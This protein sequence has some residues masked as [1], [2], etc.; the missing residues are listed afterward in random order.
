M[1][2]YY[3]IADVRKMEKVEQALIEGDHKTV[4]TLAHLYTLKPVA[5]A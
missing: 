1:A 2:P 5:A 4:S 3:D